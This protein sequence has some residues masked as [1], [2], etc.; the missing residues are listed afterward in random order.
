MSAETSAAHATQVERQ[1]K[2]VQLTRFV[3]NAQKVL[4]T[5]RPPPPW[6]GGGVQMEDVDTLDVFQEQLGGTS[7]TMRC[8]EFS[9]FMTHAKPNQSK[10]LC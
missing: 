10:G 2:Y 8:L 4:P 9:E 5:D 3:F 1:G 7:G 6:G